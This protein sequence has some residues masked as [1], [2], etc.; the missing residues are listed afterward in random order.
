MM[1]VRKK[2]SYHF[3][4]TQLTEVIV[5]TVCARADMVPIQTHVICHMFTLQKGGGSVEYHAI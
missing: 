2:N 1:W 3:L 5:R 4:R